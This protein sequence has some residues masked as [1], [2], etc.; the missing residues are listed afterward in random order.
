VSGRARGEERLSR[1]EARLAKWFPPHEIVDRET[2]VIARTRRWLDEYF[3]GVSA[4]IDDLTFDMRGAPFER[5]VWEALREIPAGA[6]TSYARSPPR[7][8]RPPRRAPSAPPTA[9]IQSRS[10][11][12]A[13]ASSDPA[14]R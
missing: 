14:A 1:L 3:A 7:S 12:R 4:A 11:S 8:A 5:R 6:T 2:P 10:S 9:P 13:T